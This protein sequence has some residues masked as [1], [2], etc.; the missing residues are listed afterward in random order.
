VARGVLVAAIAAIAVAIARLRGRP[1]R[2]GRY[3]VVLRAT[4]AAGN[5]STARRLSFTVAVGR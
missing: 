5:R 3:R 2:G 4:D 1:L